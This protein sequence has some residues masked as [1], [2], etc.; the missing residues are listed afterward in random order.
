ME[1]IPPSLSCSLALAQTV[2]V[3]AQMKPYHLF[4]LF[5]GW[6]RYFQ[7]TSTTEL[8]VVLCQQ[9]SLA[10]G[11]TCAEIYNFYTPEG[12]HPQRLLGKKRQR[13]VET[14]SLL[15]EDEG[16][17]IEVL[18]PDRNVAT[19]QLNKDSVLYESCAQDPPAW[20]YIETTDFSSLP[21]EQLVDSGCNCVAEDS[22]CISNE[23]CSCSTLFSQNNNYTGPL[24]KYRATKQMLPQYLTRTVI[25]EC[26]PNCKCNKATCSLTLFP[27][28]PATGLYLKY[29]ESG[30][31]AHTKTQIP[32]GTPVLEC[33]G[34]L[35][36]KSTEHSVK[37][38]DSLYLDRSS[39][40]LSKF[41]KEASRGNLTTV[42]VFSVTEDR[43]IVRLVLFSLCK[44]APFSEL[45]IANA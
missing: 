10:T 3:K 35:T 12:S 1:D 33:A 37:C 40:N 2:L 25:Y 21:Q 24:V 15:S 34:I 43:V 22:L 26:T 41:V 32:L 42:K 16:N 4:M 14:I 27:F 29:T 45:V 8:L 17:D 5:E 18:F 19:Y 7:E 38:S 28:T 11:I 31:S 36:Q 30:W 13:T 20:D 39:S 23:L 6:A 9:L 44:I